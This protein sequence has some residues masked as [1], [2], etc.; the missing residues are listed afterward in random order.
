MSVNADKSFNNKSN[1]LTDNQII[2][3]NEA[4]P[5]S[6]NNDMSIRNYDIIAYDGAFKSEDA[7]KYME[8]YNI[9]KAYGLSLNE[10]ETSVLSGTHENYKGNYSLEVA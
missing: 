4:N 6:G 5:P 9:L 3:T 7:A 2:N 10:E 8:F 1:L